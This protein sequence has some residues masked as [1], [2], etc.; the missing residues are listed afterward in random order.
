MFRS[1]ARA[2]GRMSVLVGGVPITADGWQLAPKETRQCTLDWLLPTVSTVT[3]G[4]PGFALLEARD[5]DG[6]T[7]APVSVA[8]LLIEY[9]PASLLHVKLRQ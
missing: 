1:T 3:A 2:A 5:A 4:R 7:L 9:L 8:T 6:N